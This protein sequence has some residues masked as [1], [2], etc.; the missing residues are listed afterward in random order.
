[1]YLMTTTNRHVALD[2]R[3]GAVLRAA[4]PELLKTWKVRA[5]ARG[6]VLTLNGVEYQLGTST[7]SVAFELQRVADGWNLPDQERIA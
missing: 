6:C 2:P 3:S 5:T 4:T 1:M 7:A